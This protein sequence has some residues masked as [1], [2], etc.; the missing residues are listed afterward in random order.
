MKIQPLASDSFINLPKIRKWERPR[1][2]FLAGKMM[3]GIEIQ[4][5]V[6]L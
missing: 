1:G 3:K 4:D 5:E 2:V 6:M